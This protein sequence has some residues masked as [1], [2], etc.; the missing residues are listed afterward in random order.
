[1]LEKK[2]SMS[3]EKQLKYIFCLCGSQE[4][5]LFHDSLQCKLSKG[6][7]LIINRQRVPYLRWWVASCR[8]KVHEFLVKVIKSPK[9]SPRSTG[10]A[11]RTRQSPF[12]SSTFLS[13]IAFIRTFLGTLILSVWNASLRLSTSLDTL[14]W[15]H[16]RASKRSIVRASWVGTFHHL[17]FYVF[18]LWLPWSIR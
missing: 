18:F 3:K 5:N 7:I 4:R 15:A 12:F 8:S 6:F 16:R 14:W 2:R 1:M 11:L 9:W 17:Y 10:C 13:G